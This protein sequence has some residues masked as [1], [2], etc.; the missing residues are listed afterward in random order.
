MTE[1]I[2]TPYIHTP[3]TGHNTAASNIIRKA[4]DI[5]RIHEKVRSQRFFDTA[6]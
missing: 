6:S 5:Q 1:N 4:G 3:N 2:A